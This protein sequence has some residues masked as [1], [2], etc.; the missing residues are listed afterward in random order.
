MYYENNLFSLISQIIVLDHFLCL[1]SYVIGNY[2][3][4]DIL[5][6]IFSFDIYESAWKIIS[7]ES[8]KKKE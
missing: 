4:Y 2:Q 8:I 6:K 1:Y 3:Y 5:F 7:Q